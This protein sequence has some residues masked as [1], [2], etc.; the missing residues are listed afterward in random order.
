MIQQNYIHLSGA[1]KYRDYAN[2]STT[3]IDFYNDWVLEIGSNDGYLLKFFNKIWNYTEFFPKKEV[4]FLST[5]V[6]I[7]QNPDYF[8][9]INYGSDYMTVFKSSPYSHKNEKCNNKTSRWKP[10]SCLHP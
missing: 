7:P 1:I 9:S 8:L 2:K 6:S 5:L 10:I 4:L 3:Y